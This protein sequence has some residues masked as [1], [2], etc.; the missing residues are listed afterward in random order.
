[1]HVTTFGVTADGTSTERS[2]APKEPLRLFSDSEASQVS[3]L[4]TDIAGRAVGQADICRPI[5]AKVRDPLGLVL[6]TQPSASLNNDL[7]TQQFIYTIINISFK[8]RCL[9][10]VYYKF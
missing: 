1:V 2:V 6:L 7:K 3:S 8:N 10:I 9:L 5:T 4:K